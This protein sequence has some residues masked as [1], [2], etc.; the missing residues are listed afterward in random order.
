MGIEFLNFLTK[1]KRTHNTAGLPTAEP[2]KVPEYEEG[3]QENENKVIRLVSNKRV[4]KPYKVTGIED[5]AS[6]NNWKAWLYLGPVV[7]LISIFLL[8]PDCSP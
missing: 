8:Y 3:L 4:T 5:V 6:K 7:V 2:E 1:K